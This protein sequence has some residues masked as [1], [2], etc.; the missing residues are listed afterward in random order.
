MK[1]IRFKPKPGQIDYTKARWVPVINCVLNYKGKILIV[2]RSENS[3]FYLNYWNGISGF[4]DDKKSL[5]QKVKE[6]LKEELGISEK[7]IKSIQLGEIF[8]QE[9]LQYKKTWI[10]HP[11][12][13][14]VRTDKIKLNWEA[15]DYKWIRLRDAK[16][17]KLLPGFEKVLEKIS[18]IKK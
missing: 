2:Q 13:V 12:L 7:E 11:V 3:N 15:K 10:V 5:E 4:L 14:K 9:A 8:H 17:L 6:E 16:K 18:L 1:K